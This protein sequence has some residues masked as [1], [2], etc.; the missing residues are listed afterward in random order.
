MFLAIKNHKYK[1]PLETINYMQKIFDALKSYER[2]DESD[3]ENYI[4]YLM[5]RVLKKDPFVLHHLDYSKAKRKID[6]K[7]SNQHLLFDLDLVVK[8]T[9]TPISCIKY[10]YATEK[11]V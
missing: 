6:E 8:S 1:F 4:D 10:N 5:N 3:N 9:N 11:N 7:W 2:E